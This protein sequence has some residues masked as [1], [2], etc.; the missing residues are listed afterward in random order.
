VRPSFSASFSCERVSRD[1]NCLA[2]LPM[3]LSFSA[4]IARTAAEK[5]VLRAADGKAYRAT[6]PDPKGEG[7]FVQE[8]TFKGSFPEQA[9]FKLEI[10]GD[11]RD[12]AG[13]KLA[14]QK[15]FPLTVKT[16]IDPP[17]VKFP[18]KFGIIELKADPT[19]PVTLRNVEAVLPGKQLTAAGSVPGAVLRIG[20]ANAR[21]IVDWLK[22]VQDSQ[23]VEWGSGEEGEESTP[24][25]AAAESIFGEQDVTRPIKVP[26]PNG[27]R[28]FEV[29]G[30]PLGK[31]GFYV[32][33]LASPKLGAAL[34]A[35]VESKA[36][37]NPAY[38]VSTS[39]LVT[40]LAVHLKRGRESSL[41]W[42]TALDTGAPVAK[43]QVSVQDCSGKEHW[44]GTTDARGIARVGVALPAYRE[45]P[46]C[47]RDYDKQYMVFAR[48]GSDV[49][50][51]MSE[52]NEGISSWRFN[53]ARASYSG[54]YIATT[55]LDRTLVRAGETVHMKHL[56]RQHTRAGFS[57]VPAA[58][59]PKKVIVQHVGSDQ[60]YEVAANWDAKNAA[61]STW[62]V[63]KDA[64][65]GV[66]QIVME[67][68]LGASDR[69]QRQQRLVRV[70]FALQVRP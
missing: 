52:W 38:H 1:A 7:D 66:Y 53:L 56:Y 61:E 35:G 62:A 21:D 59:L 11:L 27:A 43:A 30:I 31:P 22:R 2:F 57:F 47:M 16:D 32:V 64:K 13:R 63:P 24:T 19:L 41:V 34:L 10:P 70:V 60:K 3:R 20:N 26:K 4:P 37:H 42:V 6:L 58:A 40:N 33:E 69:R 48:A 17:L 55:V 39:A 50:F 36:K 15:R 54:P 29:V 9:T 14:N 67:D 45:L 65:T 44:K 12:D 5:M 46:G 18:A 51:V 25:Y 49:S 28:A 8:V 68:N 23:N